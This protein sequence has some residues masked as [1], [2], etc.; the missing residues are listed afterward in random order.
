M[1]AVP[2]SEQLGPTMKSEYGVA[3]EK[4]VLRVPFI[5]GIDL[6]QTSTAS[7]HGT[8]AVASEI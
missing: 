7:A 6:Q 4:T 8:V 1:V 2:H 3:T 5:L